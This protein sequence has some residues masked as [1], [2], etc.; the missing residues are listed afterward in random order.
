MLTPI[1]APA[2]YDLGPQTVSNTAVVNLMAGDQISLMLKKGSFITATNQPDNSM[3]SGH[4][5]YK[6]ELLIYTGCKYL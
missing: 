5:E 1:D 2:D 4:C 6:T 3:F